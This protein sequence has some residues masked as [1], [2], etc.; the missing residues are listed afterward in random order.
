M[1]EMMLNRMAQHIASKQSLSILQWNAAFQQE[2]ETSIDWSFSKH[3]TQ[4]DG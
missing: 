1:R 3:K 4:V 2:E